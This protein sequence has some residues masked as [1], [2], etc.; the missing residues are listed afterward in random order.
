M[1]PSD[2]GRDGGPHSVLDVIEESLGEALDA[3]FISGVDRLTLEDLEG[4]KEGYEAFA[5]SGKSFQPAAGEF[6]PVSRYLIPTNSMERSQSTANL[7]VHRAMSQLVY[8]HG[9]IAPDHLHRLLTEAVSPR[10]SGGKNPQWETSDFTKTGF[11]NYLEALVSMRPLMD[12]GLL[13]LQ[14]RLVEPLFHPLYGFHTTA[15]GHFTESEFSAIE[16]IGG[17]SAR[18]R[19]EE[20]WDRIR[21]G[22]QFSMDSVLPNADPGD[23][24]PRTQA[25]QSIFLKL[26]DLSAGLPGDLNLESPLEREAFTWLAERARPAPT[27]HPETENLSVAGRL[28]VPSLSDLQPA[29]IVAMH[30]SDVW[31]EYRLS[32]RRGL[33]RVNAL[34][35]ISRKEAVAVVREELQLIE[36]SVIRTSRR[37]KFVEARANAGKDLVIGAVVGVGAVPLV[38]PSS[39]AIGLATGS[40]RTATA[41]LLTWLRS[42]EKQSERA[43]ARCFGA[44]G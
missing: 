6:W 3:D 23:L 13:W 25:F 32:L 18:R 28:L 16:F 4:I 33:D 34:G 39:A 20:E 2:K 21:D 8:A 41:L 12:S 35:E 7:A 14:P 11:A 43:V 40:A 10:H 19:F 27:P 38:G 26:I 9:A 37:S 30:Q 1:N 44:L 15:D 42:R 31:T 22:G 36:Q 17:P 24:W 29:D 5:Q